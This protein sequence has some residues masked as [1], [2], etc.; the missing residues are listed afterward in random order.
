MECYA[1]LKENP[2]IGNN[3]DESEDLTVSVISQIQKNTYLVIA[4]I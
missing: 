3:M 1:A 2:A 4:L